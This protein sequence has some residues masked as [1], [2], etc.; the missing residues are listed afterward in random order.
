MTGGEYRILE[1]RM[2]NYRQY[3]GAVTAKFSEKDGVF[4]VFIGENGEGKSNLLNAI[5]WCLFE[6]EPH[7][8]KESGLPI[9]N[10]RRLEDAPTGSRIAMS[11]TVI[12]QRD[13]AKYSISRRLVGTKHNFTKRDGQYVVTETN[14]PVPEGFEIGGESN[15][16]FLRSTEDGTW[17]DQ[18]K[19]HE[20]DSLVNGILPYKLS[21]FFML[22][23]EFM[24]KF[25]DRIDK[26]GSGVM[27][28]SQLSMIE[29]ALNHVKRHRLRNPHSV[30]AKLNNMNAALQNHERSLESLN[31]RDVV[32]Y[33]ESLIPG[34]SDRYYHVSGNLRVDDLEDGLRHV[35]DQLGEIRATMRNTNAKSNQELQIRLD[36]INRDIAEY[37][38]KMGKLEFEHRT[39]L[40]TDGPKIMLND[41][42]RS[43]VAIVGIEIEAG[44]IPNR[45]KVNITTDL[46]SKGTCL[47]GTSLDD[48]SDA[49]IKVEETRSMVSDDIDLDITNDIKIA[50]DQSLKSTDVVIGK[51]DERVVSI[52]ALNKKLTK[53]RKERSSIKERLKDTGDASYA[54]LHDREKSFEEQR[55]NITRELY[56]EKGENKRRN[57]EI[58]EL[59]RKITNLNVR[60]SEAKKTRHKIYVSETACAA[61]ENV[62]SKISDHIRK[63]VQEKT[64]E[65]FKKISWKEDY[66][67]RI[68]IDRE[69]KLKLLTVH[70][71]NAIDDL[72][73]GEKLFL[74]LSFI[75]A[76][77]QIAGYSFPL[78]VDTPFGK[79]SGVPRRM[80][81]DKIPYLLPKSQLTLLATDTEYLV[82]LPNED[83]NG[84][85]ESFRDLLKRKVDVVE[86]RIKFNKKTFCSE[87]I[88]YEDVA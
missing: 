48:G 13:V 9:I 8:R 26:I 63:Q 25:F 40:I 78:V 20:F 16:A 80:L 23:G 28:I 38:D 65:F 42:L 46:L 27:R 18:T 6:K 4:S 37:M 83:Q 87:I 39:V 24:E 68:V 52:N 44:N 41:A 56:Y 17:E 74:A 22:D 58:G 72:A 76:L 60:D 79:I 10:T 82:P 14:T 88:P 21:E 2:E 11:V 59:R 66:F 86:S 62:K 57:D 43:A 15:K 47:C 31:D 36:D 67:D 3:Y 45:V 69:Y 30:D 35:N 5:N 29:N 32:I 51:I 81:A 12:L 55:E 19:T 1:V 7:K 53:L 34:T 33:T 50:N 85:N 75:A 77:R 70:G 61:L 49:R 71:Y 73:A 64:T 54:A 84:L